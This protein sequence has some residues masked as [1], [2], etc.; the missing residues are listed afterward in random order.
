[1]TEV[2]KVL[3]ALRLQKAKKRKERLERAKLETPL[4]LSEE[5]KDKMIANNTAAMREDKEDC[6]KWIELKKQHTKNVPTQSDNS[7][8]FRVSLS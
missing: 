5:E 7:Q 3:E 4:V 2:E 8:L 6:A 1:M